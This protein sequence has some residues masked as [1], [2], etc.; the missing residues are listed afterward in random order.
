MRRTLVMLAL[1]ALASAALVAQARDSSAPNTL[2]PEERAAGWRLLFDGR[3]TAG[4]RGYRK[5]AMPEGWQVIDGALTRTGAGGDIVTVEQ[6][7]SFE[8]AF[9]WT[10]APAGNSGVMFRVTEERDYPWQSGPEY[11]I[12][13][14]AGHAN[15]LTPQTSAASDYDLHAP[16]KDMTRPAGSWNASRLVVNG[17][18]VEH[19][20]NGEKVVA[21]E[22]G[23]PDWIE[24]V[25]KSKFA[26]Y[27]NWGLAPRG[28]IALQDHGDR[29]AYRNIKIRATQ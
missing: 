25:K 1:G 10:I 19:W 22:I 26:K 16:A 3:T 5:T 28:H 21:Y 8:L 6:F 2:T 20:L 7:G 27:E 18:H 17:N 13:D 12:L 14:N 29:V 9:E 11:Q 23:S 15:G 4:W 24:R